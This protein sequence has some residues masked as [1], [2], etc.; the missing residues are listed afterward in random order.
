MTS[1][2]VLVPPSPG[3][4]NGILDAAHAPSEG[5][6]LPIRKDKIRIKTRGVLEDRTCAGIQKAQPKSKA[7]GAKLVDA[8]AGAINALRD[9]ML[10][11]FRFMDL[12]GGT[13]TL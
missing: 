5:P 3:F 8:A 11:P 1:E 10:Q 7:G 9:E 4:L 12:P 2:S 13:W 6:T